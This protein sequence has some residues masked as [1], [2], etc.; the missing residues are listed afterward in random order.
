MLETSAS[1]AMNDGANRRP[2]NLRMNPPLGCSPS[3]QVWRN[4]KDDPRRCQR[5]SGS[6]SFASRTDL[7]ASY[8]SICPKGGSSTGGE[9]GIR[10]HEG[11][12]LTRF[13]VERHKPDYATSPS[14][15]RAEG[16]GCEPSQ[17]FTVHV[18][19]TC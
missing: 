7:C 10:T 2:K 18:F 12:H 1:P 3:Q 17:A 14:G 9:G 6:E 15:I 11:F 4:G 19:E 8:C 16:E 13:P 5:V